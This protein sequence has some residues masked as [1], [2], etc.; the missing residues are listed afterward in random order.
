MCGGHECA[1]Y[2]AVSKFRILKTISSHITSID[3]F[4]TGGLVD[5][6][7]GLKEY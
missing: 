4:V 2:I 1:D 3:L 6:M 7:L 5:I